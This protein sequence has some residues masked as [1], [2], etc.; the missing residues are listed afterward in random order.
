[1][2]VGFAM[3]P[4]DYAAKLM[5]EAVALPHVLRGLCPLGI[6]A[7]LAQCRSIKSMYTKRPQGA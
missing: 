6:I 2:A 3:N 5:T 7:P 4:A 1:M